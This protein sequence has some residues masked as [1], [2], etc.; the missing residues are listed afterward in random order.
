MLEIDFS[1]F[2]GKAWSKGKIFPTKVDIQ[3]YLSNKKTIKSHS[4][5]IKLFKENLKEKK[6]E[7]CGI[8]QWL[9][10][11]VVLELNHI[12]CNHLNNNINNLEI[13][14]PN[15][16]SLFTRKNYKKVEKIDKRKIR[17]IRP[18]QSKVKNKPTLEILQKEI[19]ELGY[20]G[21]GRKYGVSDNAVR[22]WLKLYLTYSN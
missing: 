17:K 4:L 18:Y 22:K 11:E 19:K 12:D 21:T 8:D 20:T 13:L 6:C 5:K 3:T 2:K 9:G 7:R 14:C 1:H 15:C 10:E 16:H